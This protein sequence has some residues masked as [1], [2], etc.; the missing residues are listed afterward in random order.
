MKNFW[1]IDGS[2]LIHR[3][4]FSS[5]PEEMKYAKTPEEK[6][7]EE[8][9]L[10]QMDGK[11]INALNGFFTTLE[12][13]IEFQHADYIAVCFDK[14]RDS[15]FRRQI[16]PEYKAQRQPSPVPL[17][18]QMQEACEI[19]ERMGIP[20]FYSDEF[21][22]DDYAGSIAKKFASENVKVHLLTTDRDYLQLLSDNIVCHM[23]VTNR[24]KMDYLIDKYGEKKGPLGTYEY[25]KDICIAELGVLPEQITDWKGIS[26]DP[27]DNIPGI[28]GVSDKSAVPLLNEYGSL[29]GIYDYLKNHSDD[30]AKERWKQ[31]GI[32]RPPVALMR[33]GEEISRFCKELAV[34]KTDLSIPDEISE[35]SNIPKR[36]DFA[37]LADE[38]GLIA[39]EDLLS[40]MT[41][42]EASK[43]QRNDE[44]EDTQEKEEDSEFIDE[45]E[46]D[47]DMWS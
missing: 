10:M 23:M 36:L 4:Y 27:S 39:L 1:V 14:N 30:E 2:S 20:T 24:N 42:Y 25:D 3:E 12:A 31:L 17:K 33:S 11:Y 34:I 7:A 22:A 37:N 28:K 18:Q 16:Y 41:E 21:E 46:S 5:L 29:E 45:Y 38:Y 43:E 9:R 8:W 40:R 44:S 26:G 32:S 15:T 6:E 35:Y 13:I 19:C 47:Y